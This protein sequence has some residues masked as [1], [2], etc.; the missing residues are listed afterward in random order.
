L[1]YDSS[2]D[3]QDYH[4][5]AVIAL[6]QGW[7]PVFED[8]PFSVTADTEAP[9]WIN[10]YPKA[11]W[12]LEAALYRVT[13]FIEY[14]KSI[15]I[16]FL[17]VTFFLVFSALLTR[18]QIKV[19]PALG[20]SLLLSITPV[21]LYQFLSFYVDCL[22]SCLVISQFVLA[23]LILLSE[24]NKEYHWILALVIMIMIIINIKFTGIV[25]SFIV[26][27]G[28]LVFSVIKQRNIQ[29][30]VKTL[31]FYTSVALAAV[32]FTGFNPYITNTLGHGHPLHPVFGKEKR[33]IITNQKPANYTEMEPVSCFCFSLLAE[34]GT[35][36]QPASG[37]GFMPAKLKIPFTITKNETRFYVLD[38]RAG[39]FGPLFS[40]II[41]I[42]LLLFILHSIRLIVQKR[43][44][45]FVIHIGIIVW[46]LASV[47]IIPDSW[48][49]R[50]IPHF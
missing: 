48:W 47:L 50:F 15:N 49:A 22:V 5:P 4:Q 45:L 20:L 2:W 46:L 26:T 39:G 3:G 21:F 14:G 23:A 41:V 38:P 32:I 24:K 31:L 18:K 1:F 34:G 9:L 13:G 33:D 29:K 44:R 6:S 12:I 25:F 17:F 11:S 16:L 30:L 8:F 37:S 42:S 28:I 36:H 19:L 35:V 10:H 43:I 40:G 27:A 7:N